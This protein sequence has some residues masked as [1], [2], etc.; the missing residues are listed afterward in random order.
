MTTLAVIRERIANELHWRAGDGR[1]PSAQIIDDEVRSAI[2]HYES[3]RTRWTETFDSLV[4]TTADGSRSYTASNCWI[5]FDSLKIID[6]GS[7][8]VLRRL[9]WGELEERDLRVTGSEGTPFDYAIMNNIIRL[10]PTPDAAYT[11]LG[12]GIRRLA[13]LTANA[14]TNGWLT[15]GEELIRSRAKMAVRINFYGDPEAITEMREAGGDFLSHQERI[16]FQRVRDETFDILSTGRTRP[17]F[18]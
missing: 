17:Y 16:A 12:S 6:S 2:A 1:I 11:L 18:I 10:Y 4:A 15:Y 5:A 8:V 3:E 14:D 9:T 7:Y 13:T